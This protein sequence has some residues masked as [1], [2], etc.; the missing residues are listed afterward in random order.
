MLG[1]RSV[2][3][4][5]NVNTAIRGRSLFT[6]EGGSQKSF[7][8]YQV[9]HDPPYRTN[10]FFMTP[11]IRVMIFLW[12]PLKIPYDKIKILNHHFLSWPS[13]QYMYIYIYIHMTVTH[14]SVYC[15]TLL[16]IHQKVTHSPCYIHQH[17]DYNSHYNMQTE[18]ISWLLGHIVN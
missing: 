8:V 14:K 2:R 3:E 15:H 1:E 11:P 13:I 5:V 10:L 16:I 17:I 7:G 9:F 18:H 12:P 6:R 4:M